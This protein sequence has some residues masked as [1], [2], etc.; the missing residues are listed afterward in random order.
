MLVP[1]K[2]KCTGEHAHLHQLPL[3]APECPHDKNVKTCGDIR[4]AG[5]MACE[6]GLLIL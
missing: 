1:G 5:A 2:V 4:S 6:K 3:E